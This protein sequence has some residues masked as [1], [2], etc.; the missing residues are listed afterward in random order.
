[1][2]FGFPSSLRGDEEEEEGQLVEEDVDARGV[3]QCRRR[4]KKREEKTN[5]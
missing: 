5:N 3:S 4:K 2:T 1:M